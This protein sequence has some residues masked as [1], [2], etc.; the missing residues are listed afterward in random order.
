MDLRELASGLTTLLDDR[1]RLA[2]DNARLDETMRELGQTNTDLAQKLFDNEKAL[3]LA[4]KALTESGV[5]NAELKEEIERLKAELALLRP[6]FVLGDATRKQLLGGGFSAPFPICYESEFYPNSV[7]KADRPNVTIDRAFVLNDTMPDW[8][9]R[10]PNSPRWISDIEW[11]NSGGITDAE[12]ARILP[13]FQA[14]RAFAATEGK[15]LKLG[16]YGLLPRFGTHMT[17]DQVRAQRAIIQPILDLLDE[18]ILTLYPI[19]A[20]IE[21]SRTYI[22][23]NIAMGREIGRPVY[24]LLW[25]VWHINVGTPLA[26]TPVSLEW[27]R[28]AMDECRAGAD[29]LAIWLRSDQPQQ[30]TDEP[31]WLESQRWRAALTG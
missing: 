12:V 3:E 16:G 29:G 28:M 23:R 14:A 22:R 24:A 20:D 30:P 1:D 6:P 11:L 27:W 26:N 9:A 25:P 15:G 4:G 19:Y 7:A 10:Y 13:A 8:R 5:Q 17:D 21:Q 18:T 31:W 2:G